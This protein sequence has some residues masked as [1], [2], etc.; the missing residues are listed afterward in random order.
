VEVNEEAV[1]TPG[2]M[3]E[4]PYD[5]GWLLKVKVGQAGTALKNLLPG[6][7]ARVLTD[8]TAERLSALMGPDLG[9]VL[10]DGGIPVSGFARQLAGER[11]HEMA[12]EL[13]M[14]E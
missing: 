14:A 8:E 2:L 4:E 3:G 1:S 9:V 5:R 7:L 13:L 12:A 10:Q 11:W 6:R